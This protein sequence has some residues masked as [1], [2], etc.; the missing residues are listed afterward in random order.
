MAPS[1]A[2]YSASFAVL[3]AI[4]K[5]LNTALENLSSSLHTWHTS[6]TQHGSQE[7]SAALLTGAKGTRLLKLITG[8]KASE[9]FPIGSTD[10]RPQTYSLLH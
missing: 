5:L 6:R 9:I 10:T 3:S 7:T 4:S 8:V 2:F 1:P